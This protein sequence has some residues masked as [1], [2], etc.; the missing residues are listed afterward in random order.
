M[1]VIMIHMCEKQS[2]AITD[3]LLR[4]PRRICTCTL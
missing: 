1:A 4:P 2:R 3:A